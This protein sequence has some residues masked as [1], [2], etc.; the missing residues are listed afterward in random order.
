MD[1]Y[2]LKCGKELN[3]NAKFCN[4]CGTPV[5]EKNAKKG[6]GKKIVMIMM[7][8]LLAAAG[9][10]YAAYAGAGDWLKGCFSKKSQEETNIPTETVDEKTEITYSVTIEETENP[11]FSYPVFACSVPSDVINQLNEKYKQEVDGY[12]AG[13]EVSPVEIEEMIVSDNIYEVDYQSEDGAIVA[14][15]KIGH[16]YGGGT[17]SMPYRE[18]IILNLENGEEL[19][20]YEAL[21]CTKEIIEVAAKSA[22][23]KDIMKFESNKSD[24]DGYYDY[25]DTAIVTLLDSD[26]NSFT[27]SLCDEGVAVSSGKWLLGPSINEV[28]VSKEELKNM[29]KIQKNSFSLSSSQEEALELKIDLLSGPCKQDP[30]ISNLTIDSALN[31]MTYLLHTSSEVDLSSREEMEGGTYYRISKDEVQNYLKEVYQM[32]VTNE[33]LEEWSYYDDGNEDYYT[34][35]T[36]FG[37]TFS[38]TTIDNYQQIT[39]DMVVFR[40]EIEDL[41]DE[42]KYNYTLVARINPNSPLCGLQLIKLDIY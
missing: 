2:C 24:S 6:G 34:Y 9:G 7:C 41:I 33:E 12:I 16:L 32:N 3:K 42:K 13:A 25:Y 14:L 21:D 20:V 10:T 31:C 39:E 11:E 36:G 26:Y 1:K 27:Y 30:C 28:V 23:M 4:E 38:S 22:F 19:E 35:F 5:M 40:G 29:E 18:G 8:A 17:S 37:D 15:S